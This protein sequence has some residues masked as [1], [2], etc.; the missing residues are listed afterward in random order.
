M[1]RPNAVLF[2]AV[3][4]IGGAASAQVPDPAVQNQ[5]FMEQ[6]AQQRQILDQQRQAY[7]QEQQA[8]T[9]QNLSDLAGAR[10][11]EPA[12]VPS[13]LPP[14]SSSLAARA[15]TLQRLA[16]EASVRLTRLTVRPRTAPDR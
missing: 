14:L 13:A 16:D 9:Q 2:L 12:P 5:I 7:V 3:L 15:L 8:R 10:R 11:G 1:A 6:Q 4:G